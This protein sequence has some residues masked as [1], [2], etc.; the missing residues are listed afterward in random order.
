MDRNGQN[1]DIWGGAPTQ[2]RSLP[3]PDGELACVLHEAGVCP[4]GCDECRKFRQ[5]LESPEII[6]GN[7]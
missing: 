4:V 6:N 1:L 5:P 2:E 7:S 3:K